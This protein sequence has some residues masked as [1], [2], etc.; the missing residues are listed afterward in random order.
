ML[1]ILIS[2][3]CLIGSTAEIEP[4]VETDIWTAPQ[5]PEWPSGLGAWYGTPVD[6]KCMARDTMQMLGE[7]KWLPQ[8]RADAT[9]RLIVN[10]MEM[11]GLMQRQLDRIR[12]E[13]VPGLINAAIDES[14][15][16]D[17]TQRTAVQEDG[18]FLSG[19]A[20][21]V[22]IVVGVMAFAGGL[23]IGVVAAH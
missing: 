22:V 23:A 19:L 12:L 11:P 14:L 17:R 3:M 7:G 4:H 13:L 1:N 16:W 18:W 2:V 15:A 5:F 21:T 8:D 6:A 9:A 20:L 10:C